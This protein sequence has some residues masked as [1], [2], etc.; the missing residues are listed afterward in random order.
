VSDD[1][2]VVYFRGIVKTAMKKKY[3]TM[4]DLRWTML[5]EKYLTPI[6]SVLQV[7]AHME[8]VSMLL[9]C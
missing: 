1:G 3:P 6:V 2:S 7:R 5:Q 8:L 4:S 9:Q